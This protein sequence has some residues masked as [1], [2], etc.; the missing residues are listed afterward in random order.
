MTKGTKPVEPEVPVF[1]RNPLNYNPDVLTRLTGLA[2]PADTFTVASQARDSEL[3]VIMQQF[4]MTGHVP[5]SLEMPSYMDFDEV[6]DYQSALHQVMRA[7]ESFM[8]IAPEIRS[9]F[10]NDPGKFL[11]FVY[12]PSNKDEVVKMFGPQKAAELVKEPAKPAD[13]KGS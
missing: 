9:R 4:G 13:E 1:V 12:D 2:C 10:D 7:Q 6:F 11:E 8:L 5:G 3:S